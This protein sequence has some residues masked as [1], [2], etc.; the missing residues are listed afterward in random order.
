M[1]LKLW[2]PFMDIDKEW[3]LDFPRLVRHGA[4]FRP[5]MD[6]VK[7]DGQL[8]LTAELPGISPDDVDISL[9]GD[10]LTIMGEK[11]EEREVAEED[12]YLH[13]RTFGS[14]Q[15]RITVPDG[16]SPDAIEASF[17][18]GV[19]TIQVNLPELKTPEA[20]RIPVGAEKTS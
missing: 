10:V 7:T 2:A 5:T 3:R 4:G 8:V 17:E 13:E 19:L 20:T 15:R 18:N 14:F 12:R 16:V 9:K 11:S 1:D 6:V